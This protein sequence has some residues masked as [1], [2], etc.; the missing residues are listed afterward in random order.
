[1]Q[2]PF[3]GLRVCMWVSSRESVRVFMCV[4][5]LLLLAFIRFFRLFFFIVVV[6]Y[7]VLYLP[8]RISHITTGDLPNRRVRFALPSLELHG[9]IKLA[10]SCV[11]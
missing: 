7:V 3:K 10:L 11:R 6:L 9:Q 8:L 5:M 1:M 2:K 4:Y